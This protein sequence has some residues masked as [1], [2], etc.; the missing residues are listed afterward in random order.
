MT[1][2][3]PYF[4]IECC[5]I[6]PCFYAEAS[7]VSKPTTQCSRISEKELTNMLTSDSMR[8]LWCLRNLVFQLGRVSC[9][10]AKGSFSLLIVVCNPS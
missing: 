4:R 1:D 7:T 8:I 10:K 5:N 3:I 6:A 2:T 9:E